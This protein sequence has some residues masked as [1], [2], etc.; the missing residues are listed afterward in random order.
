MATVADY[1]LEIVAVQHRHAEQWC[2]VCFI[3]L[4]NASLP[5]PIDH[6]LVHVKAHHTPIS[7]RGSASAHP[8]QCQRLSEVWRKRQLSIEASVDN[9]G[10]AVQMTVGSIEFQREGGF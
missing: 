5:I 3:N 2:R 4:D 1:D 10:D 8:R 6:C 7:K 9:C